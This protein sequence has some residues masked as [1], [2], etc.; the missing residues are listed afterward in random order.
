MPMK[1]E[2]TSPRRRR[3]PKPRGPY[4]KR[5][6]KITIIAKQR[7]F[8]PEKWK[9][10]LTALA[11]HFYEKQKRAEKRNPPARSK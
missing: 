5:E 1:P 8:D 11:Y 2:P 10:L 7:E 6:R 3:Q 9:A 4:A